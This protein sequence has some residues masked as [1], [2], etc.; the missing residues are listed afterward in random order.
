MSALHQ[1]TETAK[2][3][4]TI[5]HF[6]QMLFLIEALQKLNIADIKNAEAE[7]YELIKAMHLSHC[8]CN[9][10]EV[11]QEYE[12]VFVDF[13]NWLLFVEKNTHLDLKI[14]AE[15]FLTALKDAH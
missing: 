4:P 6:S 15:D 9:F 5:L 13:S 12:K 2:T 3:Y 11:T 1:L 14:L 8:D 10:L 7:F